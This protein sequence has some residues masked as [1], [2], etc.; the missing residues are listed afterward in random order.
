MI[1]SSP[2]T[3]FTKNSN[4]L[5][6]TSS[7]SLLSVATSSSGGSLTSTSLPNHGSHHPHGQGLMGGLLSVSS[8]LTGTSVCSAPSE[9]SSLSLVSSVDALEDSY[10]LPQ[11]FLEDDF[12]GIDSKNICQCCSFQQAQ[13]PSNVKES[14]SHVNNLENN[15]TNETLQEEDDEESHHEPHHD[16]QSWWKFEIFHIH[17]SL[18]PAVTNQTPGTTNSSSSIEDDNLNSPNLFTPSCS[19]PPI[20]SSPLFMS[21]SPRGGNSQSS[22]P[23]IPSFMQVNE[24]EHFLEALYLNRMSNAIQRKQKKLTLSLRR[25]NSST[26]MNREFTHHEE[27]YSS[28][29]DSIGPQIVTFV[30]SELKLDELVHSK[31][32]STRTLLMHLAARHNRLDILEFLKSCCC[33]EKC[34]RQ[35]CLQSTC[36]SYSPQSPQ[37]MISDS[38]HESNSIQNQHSHIQ[39][40]SSCLSRRIALWT[41]TDSNGCTPLFYACQGCSTCHAHDCCVFLLVQLQSLMQHANNLHNGSIV[42]HQADRFGNLPI[43]MAFKKRDWK[44][45]DLLQLFGA[46]LDANHGSFGESLLHTSVRDLDFSRVEYL[47]RHCQKSILKKNQ[48]DENSLFACLKDYRVAQACSASSLA[49]YHKQAFSPFRTLVNKS[50]PKEIRCQF[51]QQL[52]E[53]G[54]E[55][56]GRET[57]EKALVM[58]NQHGRNFF[59]EAVAFGD[60][61]AIK[62]ILNYFTL[63]YL[64]N[65]SSRHYEKSRENHRKLLDSL[66]FSKD[67]QGKNIL[68]LSLEFA[69]KRMNKFNREDYQSWLESLCF[70]LTWLEDFTLSFRNCQMSSWTNMTCPPECDKLFHEK[71]CNGKSPMEY[72]DFEISSNLECDKRWVNALDLLK[73]FEHKYV[74]ARTLESI[75]GITTHANVIM[76]PKHKKGI[77]SS[78]F[79]S[80]QMSEED[81]VQP[82]KL[83]ASSRSNSG[84]LT[85][86]STNSSLTTNSTSSFMSGSSMSSDSSSQFSSSHRK[87]SS[88]S[89]QLLIGSNQSPQ[90]QHHGNVLKEFMRKLS[91]K[92]Q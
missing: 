27:E 44:M 76:T 71:D 1:L 2:Q 37:V 21:P 57:F 31:L 61:L 23:T 46:S 86:G 18:S 83:S 78:L 8:C 24:N 42:I 67:R 39:H 52:L 22:S 17:Q 28:N 63:Q 13:H 9:A 53:N 12:N 51:I 60:V 72:I 43:A 15:G 69:M 16:I 88:L 55:L 68:H 10:L 45:C 19:S 3:L 62:T 58:K 11:Q 14:H 30:L 66:I 91:M 36:N 5:K 6:P 80:S 79:I 4:L 77:L 32:A 49:E 54:N 73:C 87:A 92:K 64:V 38:N 40:S 82:R 59:S 29:D 84:S 48:K 35:S 85:L 47:S 25:S 65:V 81:T 50:A 74:A 7:S 41:S 26:T 20:S 70:I 90:C 33:D 34:E 89:S 56:F 75:H